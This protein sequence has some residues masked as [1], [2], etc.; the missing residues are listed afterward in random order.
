MAK[1]PQEWTVIRPMQAIP[2]TRFESEDDVARL[3]RELLAILRRSG[4]HDHLYKQLSACRLHRCGADKCVEACWFGARQRR[5]G[6]IPRVYRLL[7]QTKGPI[8]EIRLSRATWA[9]P[10]GQLRFANLGWAKQLLRRAFDSLYQPHIVAVGTFKVSAVN[11]GETAYWRCE[12]DHLAAGV[13]KDKLEKAF[14]DEKAHA[15]FDFIVPHIIPVLNLGQAISRVLR[16]DL[17]PWQHPRRPDPNASPPSIAQRTEFNN[18]LLDLPV[19]ARLF[20][21]G[22]DRHWNRLSK[23]PRVFR[24]KPRKKRPYPYWLVPFMFGGPRWENEEPRD[25][26]I[27]VINSGSDYF[28]LEDEE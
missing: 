15:Q 14:P 25:F 11:D 26:S 6:E 13:D 1:D 2:P 28:N 16:R 20:R 5:L 23:Q 3:Q 12:M 19:G 18:W 22:C 27:E 8:F 24:S 9:R 17:E 4:V 21:Y 10:I 7:Q